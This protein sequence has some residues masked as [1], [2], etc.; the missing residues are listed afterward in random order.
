MKRA[1]GPRLI[2]LLGALLVIFPMTAAAFQTPPAAQLRGVL[3]NAE[4]MPATGFQLG[5]KSTA[6]DLYLA[7]PTGADGSFALD[8]L[9]AGPYQVVAFSPDGEEFPVVGGEIEL[10]PGAVER[11]EIRLRAAGHSPG[12]PPEGAGPA[13]AAQRGGSWFSRLWHSGAGGKAGLLAIVV[14]GSYGVFELLDDDD[15]QPKSVSPIT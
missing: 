13:G 12:R 8:G 5:L 10:R 3:L 1:M 14:G 6:G 2:A 4:R 15:K 9:P 7:P 11:L